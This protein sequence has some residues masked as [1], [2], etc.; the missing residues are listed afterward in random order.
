MFWHAP[1]ADK[2]PRWPGFSGNLFNL[3]TQTHSAKELFSAE[4]RGV[5]VRTAA[6]THRALRG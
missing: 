1:A 3:Q 6:L 5:T 2:S 4:S